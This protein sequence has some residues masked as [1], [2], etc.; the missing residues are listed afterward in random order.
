MNKSFD[1]QR[2][3]NGPMCDSLTF[4][5]MKQSKCNSEIPLFVP[6]AFVKAS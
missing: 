3:R 5:E 2:Q 6:S 4:K 1:G